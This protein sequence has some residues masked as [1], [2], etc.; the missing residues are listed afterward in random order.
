M[1]QTY[2]LTNKIGYAAAMRTLDM[3]QAGWTGR[4]NSLHSISSVL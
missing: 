4:R 3:H 2:A 1:K